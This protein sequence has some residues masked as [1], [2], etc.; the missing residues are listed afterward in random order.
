MRHIGRAEVPKEVHKNDSAA[1]LRRAAGAEDID[2]EED[3]GSP[4]EDIGLEGGTGCLVE[5][6]NGLGEDI[7]MDIGLAVVG[8]GRIAGVEVDCTGRDSRPADRKGMTCAYGK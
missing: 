5:V 3:K 7:E 1:A 4:V 8:I 2:L 6:D